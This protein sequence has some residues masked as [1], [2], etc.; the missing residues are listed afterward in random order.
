[1]SIQNIGANIAKLRKTKGVTQ[2]D[3]ARVVGVS[4]Q[5]VSKWENGGVPDAELFP[6]IADFFEVTIDALFGRD[7]Q[8]QNMEKALMEKLHNTSPDER[9]GV[10]FELCWVMERAFFG[11]NIPDDGAT[12]AQYHETVSPNEQHYSS[13]Q[14]DNGYT[15]MGLGNRTD[16]FFLMPEQEGICD[17]L[18]EGVDYCALFRDLG[19]EDVFNAFIL[20]YKRSADKSFTEQLL[21]RDLGVTEERAAEIIG[22]MKKYGHIWTQTIELDDREITVYQF[23]PQPYFMG[24]LV[25]AR[26]MM[27]RPQSFCYFSGGRK[28]PYLT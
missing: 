10:G 24:L 13:I 19:Q 21:V 11:K 18:L 6:V 17:K 26:D 23:S 8:V 12:V 22:I 15:H 27:V 5:A 1:M 14:T 3:L 9:I 16:F 20:L 4:A 28:K 25:F 2:D 7:V